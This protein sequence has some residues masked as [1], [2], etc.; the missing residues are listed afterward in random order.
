MS[1]RCRCWT[2]PIGIAATCETLSV[3]H[4]ISVLGTAADV[5]VQHVDEK[6]GWFRRK[7][8]PR[9]FPYL[10]WTVDGVPLRQIVAWPRPT[11][12]AQSSVSRWNETGRS[13]PTVAFLCSS[14]VQILI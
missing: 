5:V 8:V 6:V 11:T 3:E 9:G 2:R 12:F 14:A 4:Q 1:R 13:C 7:F 10:E